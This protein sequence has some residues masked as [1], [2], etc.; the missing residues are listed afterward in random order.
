VLWAGPDAAISHRTAAVLWELEGCASDVVEVSTTRDRKATVPWILLHRGARLDA[1]DRTKR[2]SMPV[3]TPTR[4]LVDLCAVLDP[5][6]LE[7]ALDDALRRGLTTLPRLRWT[8]ARLGGRGRPGAQMM[9]KVLQ[10]RDRRYSPPASRLEARLCRLLERAELP[11][12]VRQHEVRDRGTLV[13]QVDL[14]YPDMRLA[15]EADGYRY[16]SGRIAWE[17]DLIRRNALTS[18]GWMVLHVTWAD[19]SARPLDVVQQIGRALE[20]LRGTKS[21]AA[22]RTSG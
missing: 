8:A 2:G 12:P 11:A 6:L 13:A 19:L 5:D 22:S 17:R 3:T 21:D 10:A 14:A 9:R 1:A 7:G 20:G 18:R 16:H 4:T 15:I